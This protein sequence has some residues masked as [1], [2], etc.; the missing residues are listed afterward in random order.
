MIGTNVGN[1]IDKDNIISDAE[2]IQLTNMQ[3]S[4]VELWARSEEI[5]WTAKHICQWD[6]RGIAY[7]SSNIKKRC[8]DYAAN[9]VDWLMDEWLMIKWWLIEYWM[10]IDGLI[11]DWEL[12]D[13]LF[14]ID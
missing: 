14:M 10:I 5:N 2:Q 4:T 12:I 1:L 3:A 11:N 7:Y 13:D 9:T 8:D 6:L